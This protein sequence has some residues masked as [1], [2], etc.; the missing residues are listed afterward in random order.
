[1][2]TTHGKKHATAVIA[3]AAHY[4]TPRRKRQLPRISLPI[5]PSFSASAAR[6]TLA[7]PQLISSSVTDQETNTLYGKTNPGATQHTHL[8][9]PHRNPQQPRVRVQLGEP[10]PFIGVTYRNVREELQEQKRLRQLHH[11]SQLQHSD[12]S[13]SWERGS[14]LHSLQAAQQS[15]EHSF[16]VSQLV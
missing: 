3:A 9:T 1:M 7:P 12:S 15:E 13:Q 14:T 2:S 8:L 5:C 10:M 16:L 4:H 6:H 11:Q